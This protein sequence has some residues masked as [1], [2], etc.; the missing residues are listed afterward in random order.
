[1]FNDQH[2]DDGICNPAL[3]H[4]ALDVS[5]ALHTGTLGASRPC[6][7]ETWA[8]QTVVEVTSEQ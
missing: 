8:P 5:G 1:V 4:D 7:T 3:L 2:P 6:T